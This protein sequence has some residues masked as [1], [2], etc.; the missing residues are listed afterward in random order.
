MSYLTFKEKQKTLFKRLNNLKSN[1]TES[2]IEF[3]K[4][5]KAHG[6]NYI[7]QKGFIQG[8]Y[9][10]IVDFYIPK[11]FKIVIEIDGG[12]H[13]NECQVK[14]DNRKDN[15][16]IN[17]RGFKVIRIKNSEVA[18]FDINRIFN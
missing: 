10:C 3:E 4:I 14:R 16:L 12:Y 8:D 18:T 11:P 13:E 6:I 1:P 15:Y 7:F 2:E 5:L 17:E 9:Y